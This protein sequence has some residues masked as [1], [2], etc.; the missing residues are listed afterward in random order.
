M[1]AK[2]LVIQIKKDCLQPQRQPFFISNKMVIK[3]YLFF[4][5]GATKLNLDTYNIN[6]H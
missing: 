4:C 1:S 2:K 3:K 6:S 5:N